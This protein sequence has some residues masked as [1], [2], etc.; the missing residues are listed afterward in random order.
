M[1]FK[2]DSFDLTE[3]K[4]RKILEVLVCPSCNSNRYLKKKE[5]DFVCKEC[6]FKISIYRDSILSIVDETNKYPEISK[7]NWTG[8]DD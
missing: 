2:K 1:T 8:H 4:F 5:T 6:G 3:N 7:M